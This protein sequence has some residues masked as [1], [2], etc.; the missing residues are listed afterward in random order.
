M[1]EKRNYVVYTDDCYSMEEQEHVVKISATQADAIRWFMNTFNID[2][3]VEIA[4]EYEAE[5]I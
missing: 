4:E 2:G 3:C 5:E 1:E